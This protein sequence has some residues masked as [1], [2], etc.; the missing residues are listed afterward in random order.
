[1]TR[2]KTSRLRVQL[3]HWDNAEADK[4]VTILQA[5]G[6]EVAREMPE[7]SNALRKL[8]ETEPSAVV[9]DLSRRPATGR[10][11]ALAI[12]SYKALR[13][14]PIIFVEGES[15]KLAQTKKLLPDAAY[16]TWNRIRS[17]LKRAIAHPPSEPVVPSSVFAGYSGKGLHKKLGIKPHTVVAL[18]GAPRDFEKTLGGL[19]E[20]VTLRRQARGRS[21]LTLWFTKSLKDLES[22]IRPMGARAVKGGLWIVWPKKTSALQSDL[23][24][25]VV[26]KTGLANGL[27][28]YKVCSIDDTWTGLKFTRR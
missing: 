10:D 5:A 7:G 8:S 18:I 11:V 3:I 13:H 19:P 22:R 9:I 14:V 26:R 28:D 6:Y 20:G 1:M 15:E 27:V 24:Q 16:T 23:S 12:R 4:R 25:V 21:D 2:A 17:A